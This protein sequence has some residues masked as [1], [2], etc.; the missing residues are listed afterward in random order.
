MHSDV[1][2]SFESSTVPIMLN[3]TYCVSA[4]NIYLRHFW[5]PRANASVGDS[6]SRDIVNIKDYSPTFITKS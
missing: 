1:F 6:M 5:N 3:N 4:V 2:N